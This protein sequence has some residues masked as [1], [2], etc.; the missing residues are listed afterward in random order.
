M[1]M[2]IKLK[3]AKQYFHMK[4]FSAQYMFCFFSRTASFVRVWERTKLPQVNINEL[5]DY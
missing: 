3:E 4:L 2:T 5:H 1:I